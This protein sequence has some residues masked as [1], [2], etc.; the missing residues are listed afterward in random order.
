MSPTGPPGVPEPGDGELP[1]LL[2]NLTLFGRL[3]RGIGLP[4]SSA[5][6]LDL[7]EALPEIEI[8]RR[9]EFHAAARALL[10]HRKEDRELFDAA[11]TLFWETP[12]ER[13]TRARLPGMTLRRQPQRRF[14]L[15][16]FRP[17][18]QDGSGEENERPPRPFAR[19]T[20]SDRE[21]LEQRDFSDLDERELREVQGL[22]RDAGWEAARR[23]VVRFRPGGR[24]FPDLRRTLRKGLRSGGEWMRLERRRH[25]DRPRPIIVLADVSGSMEQ[26]ARVLLHFLYGLFH[27]APG[28]VEAFVFATRL[29]RITRKLEYRRVDRALREASEAVRDWSGGTRIGE[30]LLRF[31]L[32]WARRLP[33]S[34]AVVLLVSDGWDRGDPLLV[35][36]EMERLRGLAWRIVWLNPLLGDADYEP[37]TRGMM[38]ALPH[39]HD[40]LPVNNLESVRALAAHLERLDFRRGRGGIPRS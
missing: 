26:T 38:A 7:A 39:V 9:D 12:P 24:R 10:I 37:L 14:Q 11:F 34:S 6:M 35:A 5:R 18:G 31:N 3:L 32:D 8:F 17:L 15:A 30:A 40:F 28:R 27:G 16:T 33:T 1:P 36:S 19:R 25:K 23:R 4:V 2:R 20:W 13:W 22:I 21:V 29:T